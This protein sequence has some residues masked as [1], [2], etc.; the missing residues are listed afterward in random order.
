MSKPRAIAI[1]TGG[2]DVPGLNPCIKTLAY[3][4]IEEGVRVLG[5]RRGWAGLLHY[6]PDDPDSFGEHLQ[7]LDKN[8]VRTID[9]TGGTYLHTSRTNPAAVRARDV[10]DFLRDRVVP[11]QERT[12]LTAHVLSNL[13][14]LG[15]DALIPIGGDDTLSFGERLHREKFP[16]IAVPKTMD[17]DVYGTDYCIGFST[18]VT[19]SVNFI[20][21]L[22]T[23]A[24]SHERIAVVELFGR[25]CGET[26]LV[27][28]YLSG[29]D[30]AVISEVPFDPER[31]A[32]LVQEDKRANPSNYAMVT[33]SEGAR[34]AGGEM[35]LSG[36]EDPYGHRKLGGIGAETGAMLKRFTGEDIIFQQLSYLMRSGAPDSL[37]LMV[38]VNFASM[39][40]GLALDG[41][42]GRLVALSRGTYTDIPLSTVAEGRKRVD[43][44]ELY[45][46]EQYR[47]RVRH[48]PGKPMF[49]Y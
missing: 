7:W 2:G 33:I 14:R 36:D 8:M 4:A 5:V 46:A 13:D 27:A 16:V 35:R 11:G 20:H 22:R 42:S 28:A 48:V 25:Y 12:D 24:G 34:T 21:A 19:R 49:L 18:A 23:S 3:R 30:R 29:A 40:V 43:V 45:D 1:L 17:N 6:N 39:A 10:P 31:L 32:R 38:A 15:V 37:D 26:S 44:E 9:R 41:T 47:P